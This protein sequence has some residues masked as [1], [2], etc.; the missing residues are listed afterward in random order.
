MNDPNDQLPARAFE[1]AEKALADSTP[2]LATR[3]RQTALAVAL[4]LVRPIRM[5][6]IAALDTERHL[7]F[8]KVRPNRRI[9]PATG[10]EA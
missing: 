4:I 9:S 3:G 7:T 10:E 5:K 6:N 2:T 1:A 8:V